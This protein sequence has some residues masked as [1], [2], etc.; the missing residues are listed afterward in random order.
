M[1]DPNDYE[2]IP[3]V[4]KRKI[5]KNI[6]RGR[7]RKGKKLTLEEKL[8]R[9]AEGIRPTPKPKKDKGL[10]NNLFYFSPPKKMQSL[11]VEP[12]RES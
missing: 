6:E 10:Y 5:L 3:R 4:P 1:F 8:R 12:P 7:F 2:D 9:F 11:K